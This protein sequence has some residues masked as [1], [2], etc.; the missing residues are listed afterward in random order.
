MIAVLRIGH[1]IA[2][3][4]RITTHVFLA[5][6]ALGADKGILSGEKDESIINSVEKISSKWGGEFKIEYIRDWKKIIEKFKSE[7]FKVV[8]LTMYGMRIQDKIS[9]IKSDKILIVV[10]GEKVPP[11]VYEL[12]DFNIAVSNQPHSEVA[13][14]AV[15]LDKHF[16]GNELE[17]QFDGDIK[18]IPC[19]KGKRFA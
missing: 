10:G 13:A 6:R 4:K 19:E 12:A 8:H 9:K 7:G 1:R 16:K 17:K 18:I 14:L 2:R 11:E 15:F 3:D 5:A